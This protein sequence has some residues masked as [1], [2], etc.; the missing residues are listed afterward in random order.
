MTK[1]TVTKRDL[2]KGVAEKNGITLMDAKGFVQTVLDQ[3]TDEL[4]AGNRIELRGFGVFEPKV[5]TGRKARNPRTGDTVYTEDSVTVK[6]KIGK[7]MDD[8]VQGCLDKLKRRD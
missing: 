4:S 2:A 5:R 8:K 6:F 1:R 7:K 3:I